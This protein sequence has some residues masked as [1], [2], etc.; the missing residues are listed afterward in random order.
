ML[1]Y[2][3]VF[4]KKKKKICNWSIC[5][6]EKISVLGFH[7]NNSL[8]AAIA[9]K[10]MTATRVYN[11]VCGLSSRT[12]SI[13]TDVLPLS[14]GALIVHACRRR[15]HYHRQI[16]F[17]NKNRKRKCAFHSTRSVTKP[18]ANDAGPPAVSERDQRSGY[19]EIQYTHVLVSLINCSFHD[20]E[21]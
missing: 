21:L 7:N 9:V 19:V 1:V 8:S 14:A 20:N 15:S 10:N 16:N 2:K 13:A 3:T 4:K 18:A 12:D 5:T 17:S 6:P 11:K